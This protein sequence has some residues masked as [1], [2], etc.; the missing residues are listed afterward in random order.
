[1]KSEERAVRKRDSMWRGREVKVVRMR[2]CKVREEGAFIMRDSV[3]GGT[4]GQ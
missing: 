1:M 4:R 2:H 3:W